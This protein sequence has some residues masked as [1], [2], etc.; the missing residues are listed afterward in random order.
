MTAPAIEFTSRPLGL[1]TMQA[2]AKAEIRPFKG[3][4]A[5]DMIHVGD[6]YKDLKRLVE[7]IGGQWTGKTHWFPYDPADVFSTVLSAGMHPSDNPYDFY[8]TPEEVVEN[9]L[10]WLDVPGDGEGRTFLEPSGGMGGFLFPARKRFP[11][12]TFHVFEIDPI[13]RAFLQEAGFEL[14]GR[15]FLK[16]KPPLDGY[17]VIL[18]NPPFRGTDYAKHT[19]RAI[20][21]LKHNGVMGA[22]AP[23]QSF[24]NTFT[25][26]IA[27]LRHKVQEFGQWEDI[28][29]PFEGTDVRCISI[30]YENF[31]N[32]LLWQPNEGYESY[33][34]FHAAILLESQRNVAAA[35]E[36]WENGSVVEWDIVA[37]VLDTAA[38][39]L[40]KNGD[41]FLWDGR[42]SQQLER[43]YRPLAN[44]YTPPE[45][46]TLKPVK[47]VAVKK[48]K[49]VAS[50]MQQLDL[51]AI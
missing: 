48:R 10:D 38:K 21:L 9:L 35:L 5:A 17:D 45:E 43:A 3:G 30:K 22:I 32:S 16:D 15:D 39:R 42:V 14:V 29:S 2:I 19:L 24:F 44:T 11:K 40:I 4:Y 1:R 46:E 37:A 7:A 8:G 50:P 33:Y 51:F 31:D 23:S 34:A 18:T 13:K 36:A 26:P 6:E 41:H 28:G 49:K 27:E 12:A 25:G 20:Q 47:K